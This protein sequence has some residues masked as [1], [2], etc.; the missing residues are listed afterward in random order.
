MSALRSTR[1]PSPD[2]IRH[3]RGEE[4]EEEEEEERLFYNFDNQLFRIQLSQRGGRR[5]FNF[6]TA[7]SRRRR[8]ALNM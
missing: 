7:N 1:E 4:E 6:K 8:R 2:E 3:S 5:I